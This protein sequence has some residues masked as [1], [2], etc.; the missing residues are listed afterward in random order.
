MRKGAE[1]VDWTT[2]EIRFLVDAAGRLPRREI[3]QQLRRSKKSVERTAAR[4]GLS[5]RCYKT[6]LVWCTECASWRG[7]VDKDTGKCRVCSKRDHL[8]GREAA[9]ADV[10]ASMTP[11]Q[12]ATY[13]ESETLRET[14]RVPTRP[15]MPPCKNG[16]L[17]ELERI[18]AEHLLALEAW[19]YRCLKYRYD[20]AKVRLGRMRKSTGTNPRKKIE[21]NGDIDH[22]PS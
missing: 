8:A 13:E 12:R 2:S 17:Y 1:R 14:R 4:L 18:K 20:A 10:M 15:T 16:S 21:M 9:C 11:E 7:Y 22:S 3:C 5:L 19:E 6:Q